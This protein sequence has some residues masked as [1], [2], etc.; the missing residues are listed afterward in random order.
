[1]ET[2]FERAMKADGDNH[3][4]C[5]TKLD[6]LDPK[7]HGS[8][9][10]MLAF[11]RACGATKNWRAGL[12]LLL[13]DAHLRFYADLPAD[14][15]K[16][17]MSS[18]DVWSDIHSVFDEYLKHRP[19]DNVAR[20]KYAMLCYL[21][22]HYEEGYAQFVELGDRMTTWPNFPYYPL[23]TMKR[24]REYTAVV[25]TKKT[26][27]WHFLSRQD[28][29]GK[30]T[31]FSPA[32]MN[33]GNGPGILGAEECAVARCSADGASYAV[34]LESVPSN[35]PVSKPDAVLDAAR[36]GLLKQQG[37][38]I[39]YQAPI[40]QAG[41]PGANISST[42][43]PSDP[44]WCASG[45][46]W[47]V[48]TLWNSRSPPASPISSGF[49]PSD[50]STPSRSSRPAVPRTNENR[51]GR[52]RPRVSVT[53][54]NTCHLQHDAHRHDDPRRWRPLAGGPVFMPPLPVPHGATDDDPPVLP[55]SLRESLTR[56]RVMNISHRH[57]W[58]RYS[59]A[60]RNGLGGCLG[61]GV[62][63]HTDG[64]FK[65]EQPRVAVADDS[66]RGK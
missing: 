40:R 62:A 1:M 51:F 9:E 49:P 19:Q 18:P 5:F 20:S 64:R 15:G 22:Q 48:T 16:K 38:K 60:Y 41:Q 55:L 59:Y 50:S 10:E 4:A 32:E 6:W 3:S 21:G 26:K 63:C 37:G 14:E 24:A 56:S 39:L 25:V 58:W 2:W 30:L 23:D 29:D 27:P 52:S 11:G 57:D 36:A 47:S 45:R 35:L 17:Y 54:P 66:P 12:T 7:W 34:R 42:R 8:H 28:D 46:S 65:D 31:V 43:L 44:R 53:T 33:R 13:A 61:S